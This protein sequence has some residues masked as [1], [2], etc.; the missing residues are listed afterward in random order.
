MVENGNNLPAA[1]AIDPTNLFFTD[2][3][4]R[5]AESREKKKFNQA[6]QAFSRLSWDE[7][8]DW[9]ERVRDK[10]PRLKPAHVKRGQ[11]QA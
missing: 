4:L 7:R 6:L 10:Y 3:D 11:K 9:E 2:E 1:F 8:Y 5:G